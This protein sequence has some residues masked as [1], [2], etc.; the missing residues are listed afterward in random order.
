MIK[1]ALS[2]LLCLIFLTIISSGCSD[3]SGGDLMSFSLTSDPGNIDPQIATNYNAVLII[4]NIY[5][6]LL[7]VSEDGSL[8]P[9]VAQKYDVSDD[10][11]TYT[12]YLRKD[13]KW[14]YNKDSYKDFHESPVTSYD[15]LFAFERLLDPDT[16][17]SYASDYYCIKNAK[18]IHSG[19]LDMS[20]LGV[21]A[22]DEY[23][24]V[25][26]LEYS[27]AMFLGL[28]TLSAAMPCN[29]DF[30]EQTKGKYGLD[31][32]NILSNGPFYINSWSPNEYVRIRSNSIYS[33]ENPVI[34]SGANLTVRDSEEV[35]NALNNTTIDT[36][37]LNYSE[38]SKLQ[39]SQFYSSEFENIVW[40]IGFNMKNEALSI[41]EIR[42]ALALLI[43]Y[44]SLED[45]LPEDTSLSKNIVPPDITIF[46]YNF[47]EIAGNDGANNYDVEQAKLNYE[48][49]KNQLDD[50]SLLSKLS[51]IVPEK[52]EPL[53]QYISQ[54]WQK[55]L[56]LFLDI[57]AL[58]DEEYNTRLSTKNF[59]LAFI[60]FSSDSNTPN[61]IL[62]KFSYNSSYNLLSYSSGRFEDALN[63]ANKS[64]NVDEMLS[65]FVNSEQILLEDACLIPLFFQKEYFVIRNGISGIVFDSSSK[66]PF[67]KYAIKS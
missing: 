25:I 36:G 16:N 37:V 20:N 34:A 13:A 14:Y 50:V 49:G 32:R 15:F 18:Q 60:S 9:G 59:D 67:F 41:P 33:S 44:N 48:Q 35:L 46:Q 61:S 40:G 29:K 7:T 21:T 12:F 26:E 63:S 64:I 57:E 1:K 23:A 10:G 5:E 43:D 38:H 19:E 53:F 52:Y 55:E 45:K 54:E 2:L 3:K 28:L 22:I 6:G 31:L 51:I 8:I 24:L 17:S 56:K 62:S 42:K 39:S 58:S 47:Q 30:F 65:A 4:K 11:L 27:N 66:I